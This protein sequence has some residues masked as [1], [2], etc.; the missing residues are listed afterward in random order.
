MG[1]VVWW[2]FP[3]GPGVEPSSP[4]SERLSFRGQSS[5]LIITEPHALAPVQLAEHSVFF[6]QVCIDGSVLFIYPAREHHY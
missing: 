1:I 2:D 6:F 5:P 3:I 4:P